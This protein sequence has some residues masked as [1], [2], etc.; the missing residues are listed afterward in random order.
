[1]SNIFM[2]PFR[3]LISVHFLTC[4]ATGCLLMKNL[5]TELNLMNVMEVPSV[6]ECSF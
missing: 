6:L 5:R 1:M 3:I 2:S 4:V